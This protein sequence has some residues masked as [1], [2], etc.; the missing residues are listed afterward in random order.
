MRVFVDIDGT[1]TTEQK[2]RSVFK[3]EHRQ[4]VI[5]KVKKLIDE[6]HEIV[7]W[8]GNTR[9]AKL[10]AE[11]LGI[12]AIAC[13][14]KPDLIIDNEVERWGRRLKRRVISPEDFLERDL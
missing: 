8:T 13:V 10:A 9:Y 14:G 7:L 12:N 4:D 11:E 5:D 1:L 6:G 3:S 2:A